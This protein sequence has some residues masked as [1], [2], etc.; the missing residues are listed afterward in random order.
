MIPTNGDLLI[1]PLSRGKPGLLIGPLVDGSIGNRT[2][3]K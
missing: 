3:I 1:S 2:A